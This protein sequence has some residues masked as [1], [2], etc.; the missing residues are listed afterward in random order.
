ICDDQ[1]EGQRPEALASGAGRGVNSS[2]GY[3]VSGAAGSN[4]IGTGAAMGAGAAAGSAASGVT[5]STTGRTGTARNTLLGYNNP[6]GNTNQGTNPYGN[7]IYFVTR[8]PNGSLITLLIKRKVGEM[9]K[10]LEN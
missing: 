4:G 9:L 2:G 3:S 8:A 1:E 5:G 6:N 7:R 10:N